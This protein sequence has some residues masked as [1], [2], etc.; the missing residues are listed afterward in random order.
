MDVKRAGSYVSKAMLAVRGNDQGLPGGKH[1]PSVVDP[2]FGFA[3]NHRQYFLDHMR[4]RWCAATRSDPLLEYAKAR[5]AIGGGNMHAGFDSGAPRFARLI[6]MRNN[7]HSDIP[8][9]PAQEY[10]LLLTFLDR[11]SGQD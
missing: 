5:R 9:F 11:N 1:G 3:G 2:H 7:V 6:L 4:M 8:L 10:Y